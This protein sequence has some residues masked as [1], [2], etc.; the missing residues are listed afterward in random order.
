[1]RRVLDGVGLATIAAVSAQAGGVERTS[2]SSAILFEEGT[3]AELTF[4]Q[5]NPTV[6]GAQG[7]LPAFLTGIFPPG[8]STGDVANTY[9]TVTLGFKT[10]I[11]DDISAALV[12]DQPIGADIAYLEPAY[13]YGFGSGSTAT[14]DS[15]A[16]TLTLRYKINDA[17]S[18][19]GGVRNERVKGK[20][21]LFSFLGTPDYDLTT[22]TDSEWGY[23]LGV[24]WEKPDI[25]A[26]VALTYV[27][28]IT[29]TLETNE[30]QGATTGTTPFDTTVPQSLLLE[31][32]T[33]IAANTLLFGSVKWTDW[34]EFDI[35]PVLYDANV[36]GSL[37]SYDNDVITYSLGVGRRFSDS[38]SGAVTLGYEKQ[39]GGF[40]GNLGPTDGFVSLGV[41]ATYTHQKIEISGGARYI[42]I[43]D[44]VTESPLI[45]GSTQGNFTGNSGVAY[46][47]KIAY[48]F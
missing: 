47:L 42:W 5:V 29:H 14:V 48:N 15:N 18:V 12:L 33:G 7:T 46:G 23:V 2:F 28:A 25:A 10:Q 8:A 17:F 38:W 30:R 16:V 45:A 11:T 40:A 3:Y 19:Y 27:S 9:T 43:G 24:A 31:A 32:Q 41:G 36:G 1:M 37:V 21:S 6:S 13:L 34:T 4:A 22:N 35:T 26:R 44:A 20:V 39:Q